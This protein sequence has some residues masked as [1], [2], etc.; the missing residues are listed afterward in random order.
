MDGSGKMT[1]DVINSEASW[2]SISDLI[3]PH[4]PDLTERGVDSILVARHVT[5]LLPGLVSVWEMA[6]ACCAPTHTRQPLVR[7]SER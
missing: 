4:N 5:V 1:D 6:T 7:K 3:L 2:P